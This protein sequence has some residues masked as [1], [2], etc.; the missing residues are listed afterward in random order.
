MLVT[1]EMDYTM[2]IVRALYRDGQLSAAAVAK[3]ENMPKAVTLKLLKQLSAA[4]LVESRRG[5]A[6]GYLLAK[7]PDELT[8]YDLLEAVGER[9]L[10]NRCQQTGYRC[11]NNTDGGCGMCT[12]FGRIQQALDDALRRVPLSAVYGPAPDSSPEDAPFTP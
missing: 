9:I 5:A 2:R 8:M 10:V 6:G 7:A 11:E 4:G 3:Q 1:R 12:E